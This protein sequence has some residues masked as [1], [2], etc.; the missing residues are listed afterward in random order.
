M[1]SS[2]IIMFGV[3]VLALGCDTIVVHKSETA[4][5]FDYDKSKMECSFDCRL[6]R[7]S[8][9]NKDVVNC[10]FSF[11]VDDWGHR[12][13]GIAKLKTKME[14]DHTFTTTGGLVHASEIRWSA[15][16]NINAYDKK[17]VLHI[18]YSALSFDTVNEIRYY[19]EEAKGRSNFK[20]D[21]STGFVTRIIREDDGY[22]EVYVSRIYLSGMPVPPS[23]IDLEIR[24]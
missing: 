1:K 19:I 3:T 23:V 17:I 21:V 14:S 15:Y 11:D 4:I 2:Y 10:A 20:V 12:I 24:N 22:F 9:L 6:E 16:Q 5:D 18:L 7:S 8:D 13:F